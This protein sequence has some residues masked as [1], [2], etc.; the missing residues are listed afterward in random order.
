MESCLVSSKYKIQH[1]SVLNRRSKQ[2]SF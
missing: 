2:A 1:W